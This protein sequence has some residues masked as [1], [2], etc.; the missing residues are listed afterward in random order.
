MKIKRLI[1]SLLVF[2]MILSA[3]VAGAPATDAKAAT[4]VVPATVNY[5]VHQQG[6]GWLP[7]VQNG[8]QSGNIG[9]NKRIEALRLTVTSKLTGNIKYRAYVQKLGWTAWA[10][11]GAIGGTTGQKLR[12]EALQIKITGQLLQNYDVYYRVYVEGAGWL[13]WAKN[14]EK[15][16]SGGASKRIESLQVKLVRKDGGG[17]KPVNGSI[18]EPYVTKEFFTREASVEEMLNAYPLNPQITHDEVL[19]ARVKE[20][21]DEVIT[22]NMTTYEKLAAAYSWIVDNSEYGEGTIYSS[23]NW[24]N[25][26]M[27][28]YTNYDAMV[29]NASY[30]ILFEGKGSCHNYAAA[31][32]ILARA[33]GVDAY[34]IDG[35]LTYNEHKWVYVML[36]GKPYFTDP[37]IGDS[38]ERYAMMNRMMFFFQTPDKIGND[39]YE[40]YYYDESKIEEYI[41]KFGNFAAWAVL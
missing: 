36:N 16:G 17:K 34:W 27:N 33:I 5:K 22:S 30:S 1:A 21:L 39:G 14:G 9:V 15:A 12:I 23:Y 40:N 35:N 26:K 3:F 20:I 7:F 10:Q 29:V 2:G 28:Y 8:K 18:T 24:N 38:C 4:S 31:F 11:N 6:Y 19:D 25:S 13:G 41:N 37:Q 32:V